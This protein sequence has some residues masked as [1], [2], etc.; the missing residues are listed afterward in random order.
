MSTAIFVH[1]TG[2]R[3]DD[4]AVTFQ[5]I[6]NK[7]AQLSSEMKLVP[8]LWG[9]PLGTKLNADGASIP[10]YSSKGGKAQSNNEEDDSIQLWEK[11]YKDPLYEIQ[12]LSLR[13]SQGGSAFSRKKESQEVK[14]RLEHLTNSPS[15]NLLDQL[16]EVKITTKLFAQA[17]ENIRDSK[18]YK[19][20]LEKRLSPLGEVYAAF[21]RAIVAEAIELCD[22]EFI[23][24]PIQFNTDLRNRTVDSITNELSQGI[25]GKG[26]VGDFIKNQF[27]KG[28][29]KIGD[30]HLQ[31][32]RGTLTD[33]AY[34]F[35]GDILFYQAKGE[36][37]RNFI[38]EQIEN[39]EPPVILLAHSLGGIACVDLLIE[40]Q[41][42]QVQLLVTVGSQ[43]PFLYEIDALQSLSYGEPLPEYFPQWLNIYDLRDILSYVGDRQGLFPGRIKDVEVDNQQPFPESHGAYWYNSATWK[44]ILEEMR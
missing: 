29:I 2:G 16:Q 24:T 13:P 32:K 38:R 1:G 42:P 5:A 7:I 6:E 23:Y 12:I 10:N 15:E 17:V 28:L 9:E 19:R 39:A 21:A 22:R 18:P 37:I 43:A 27:V 14:N 8:C 33:A 3:K 30:K 4:Y 36:K 35:T 25:Q 41:L 44:A 40:Q 31:R 20:L 26:V 11:I 34:P